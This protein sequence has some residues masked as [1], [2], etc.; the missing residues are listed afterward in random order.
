MRKHIIMKQIEPCTWVIV[1]EKGFLLKSDIKI[2]NLQ[3]ALDYINRYIS[4]Y[5][6]WTYDILILEEE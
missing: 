3:E 5:D 2:G 6:D 1:S 4:S